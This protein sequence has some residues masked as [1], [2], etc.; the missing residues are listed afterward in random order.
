[1]CAY[2]HGVCNNSH[3]KGGKVEVGW[4]IKNY[5]MGTMHTIRLMTILKVKLQHYT[6]YPCHK[7]AL[8]P[9]IFIQTF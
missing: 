2:G 4:R 5:L 6:M 3:L 7:V 1:M 9:L 8:V